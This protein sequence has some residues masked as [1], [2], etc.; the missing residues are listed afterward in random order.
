MVTTELSESLPSW[1]ENV[2]SIPVAS[3]RVTLTVKPVAVAP[4]TDQACA[5]LLIDRVNVISSAV[6]LDP[7]VCVPTPIPS[8]RIIKPW[9]TE[10]APYNAPPETLISADDF[11]HELNDSA[12]AND[13]D[14]A[15]E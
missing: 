14:A 4:A 1:P 5:P 7:C 15:P 12:D 9:L 3:F 13:P 8:G 10:T 6:P 11:K 2:P